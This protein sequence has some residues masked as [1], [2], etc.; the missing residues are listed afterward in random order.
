MITYTGPPR[1]VYV[2]KTSLEAE[3]LAV[4]HSP[5]EGPPDIDDTDVTVL[6]WA[7][8]RAAVTASAAA[9]IVA[10]N[11]VD[12]FRRDHSGVRLEVAGGT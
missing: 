12:R 10:A 4:T 1:G 6:V 5:V 9:R 8:E 2:L 3:G 7:A 11:A